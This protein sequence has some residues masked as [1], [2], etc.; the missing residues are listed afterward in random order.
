M[1]NIRTYK[2]HILIIILVLEIIILVS[3]LYW[4]RIKVIDRK[5]I[6]SYNHN[7]FIAGLVHSGFSLL[8]PISAKW[9]IKILCPLFAFPSLE[10]SWVELRCYNIYSSIYLNKFRL[11]I[12]ANSH[13]NSLPHVYIFI[14]FSQPLEITTPL[15]LIMTPTL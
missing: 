7:A 13:S 12:T 4:E 6:I 5:H 14:Y 2:Y 3:P 1:F 8:F 11:G 10:L 9:Y 15:H